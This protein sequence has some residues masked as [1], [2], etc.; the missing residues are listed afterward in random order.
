[1]GLNARQI[2]EACASAKNCVAA[3]ARGTANDCAAAND[4]VS[5]KRGKLYVF[6]GPSGVGKGTVLSEVKMR[7]D[8][9]WQSV[10]ATTR[11]PRDGEIDG[12]SYFF[13]SEDDFKSKIEDDE[14][15][16]WANYAGNFYGTPK[17]SVEK[18]LNAGQNVFLEIDVQGAMQIKESMPEAILIFIEPPS[19][20]ELKRRLARRATEDAK[21]LESRLKA[22]EM[23]LSRKIEYDT[24]LVNEDVNETA[25]E[26]CLLMDSHQ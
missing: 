8:D 3:K 17:S 21:A 24:C 2:D 7:R 1:M 26:I 18:H 14:F 6:S 16:E 13:V 20:E 11:S 25:N 4:L 10:S 5:A 12:V 19:I 9:I 15:L 23:E 22:A